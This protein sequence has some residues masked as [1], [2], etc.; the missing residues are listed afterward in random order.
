[1]GRISEVS[2]IRTDTTTLVQQLT[3]THVSVYKPG[4][5]NMFYASQ[6]ETENWNEGYWAHEDDTVWQ[7]QGWD[8]WQEDYFQ[9]KREERK[10]RKRKRKERSW[11][12]TRSKDK[13]MGKEKQTM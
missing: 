4:Y 6:N 2:L 12:S 13:V 7:S 3:C 5:A 8:E 11:T 10:E 1:M 9:G